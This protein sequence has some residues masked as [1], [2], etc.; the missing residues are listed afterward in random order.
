[1]THKMAICTYLTIESKKQ[2]MKQEEQ[3]LN[4]GY[5]DHFDG[6]QMGGLVGEWVKR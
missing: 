4:Y 5:G 2:T 3:R 6:Y 1:M